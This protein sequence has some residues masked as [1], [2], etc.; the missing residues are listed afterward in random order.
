MKTILVLAFAALAAAVGEALLSY[1]MRG[2]DLSSDFGRRWPELFLAVVKNAY[3]ALGVLFL[4]VFF[5]LYL[6]TLSWADLSFAMPIT[7]LSYVFA[8]VLAK[9]FLGE[10]VSWKRWVGTLLILLGITLVAMDKSRTP[11]LE[12]PGAELRSFSGESRQ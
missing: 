1:G 11:G 7:A 6:A 10:E 9:V 5:F 4:A 3:V 12:K 2:L 8:A